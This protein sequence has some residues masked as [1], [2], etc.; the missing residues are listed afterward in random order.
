MQIKPGYLAT[1]SMAE[2]S[3]TSLSEDELL[4]CRGGG[5]PAA[6]WWALASLIIGN[7]GDV[8]EGFSDGVSGKPPRYK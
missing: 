8:R 6:G 4:Y 2:D 3:I 1:A 5:L 7:W